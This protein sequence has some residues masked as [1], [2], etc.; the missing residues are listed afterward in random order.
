M[1]VFPIGFSQEVAFQVGQHGT[2]VT[3]EEVCWLTARRG[4]AVKAVMVAVI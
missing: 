3:P 2:C 1:A 4:R